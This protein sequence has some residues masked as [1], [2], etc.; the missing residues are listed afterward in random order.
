MAFYCL[1]RLKDREV[2]NTYLRKYIFG[3]LKHFLTKE[4]KQNK[5]RLPDDVTEA[6]KSNRISEILDGIY[7]DSLDKEVIR[8]LVEGYK[9]FEIQE[10]LGINYR[11]IRRIKAYIRERLTNELSKD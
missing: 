2:N 7:R 8:L 5:D 4:L 1:A 9:E 6:T 10:I 3:R 11:T